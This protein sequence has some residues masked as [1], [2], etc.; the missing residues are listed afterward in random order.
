M[1]KE[2]WAE[3]IAYIIS[4]FVCGFAS[5]EMMASFAPGVALYLVFAQSTLRKP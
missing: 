4:A 1:T 2:G 5:Y 3:L